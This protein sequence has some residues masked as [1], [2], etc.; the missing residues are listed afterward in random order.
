MVFLKSIRL[1]WLENSIEGYEVQNVLGFWIIFFGM[2]K[3]LWL[4]KDLGCEG[5]HEQP[6]RNAATKYNIK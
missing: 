6:R 1:S 4:Y 2:R 5:Q 3:G